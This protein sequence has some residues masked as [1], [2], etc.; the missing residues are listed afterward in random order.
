MQTFKDLIHFSPTFPQVAAVMHYLV[1]IYPHLAWEPLSI[2][3]LPRFQEV[4]VDETAKVPPAKD[5][6]EAKNL[7]PSKFRPEAP[8]TD[9]FDAE[10]PL[11]S[12]HN[13][14]DIP[15]DYHPYSLQ[16]M[17]E[18]ARERS[19]DILEPTFHLRSLG[20]VQD[21]T[22]ELLEE[23]EDA[24]YKYRK[25][26]PNNT[27]IVVYALRCLRIAYERVKVMSSKQELCISGHFGK[28][29]TLMNVE[30]R[31][32][33]VQVAGLEAFFHLMGSFGIDETLPL[34]PTI[35]RE[36]VYGKLFRR[37]VRTTIV[38]LAASP[39]PNTDLRTLFR[40]L[41]CI[42][43][44]YHTSLTDALQRSGH[45]YHIERHFRGGI[46]SWF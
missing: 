31:S 19:T 34:P 42:V 25:E 44:W 2:K 1:S 22:A 6:S 43:N 23:A 37:V 15:D 36:H 8:Y 32:A 16:H 33:A 27:K 38:S 45:T 21:G 35:V 7:S 17:L 20:N 24:I 10:D 39:D 4:Y 28:I 30:P 41:E 5:S 13:H 29:L 26:Y 14:G 9:P 46:F 11:P 18:V 12:K 3:D 40:G